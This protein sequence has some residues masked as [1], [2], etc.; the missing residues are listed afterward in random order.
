M[1]ED[2]HPPIA[3]KVACIDFDGTI[4]PWGPLMETRDPFPGAPEAIQALKANGY[5]IVIYTSRL[6]PA[7]LAARWPKQP[8]IAS[9][10]KQR[11]HIIDI[12]DRH[13]IPWDSMT[14]EK[15]PAEVYFDDKAI[16]VTER[17]PLAV[18]IAVFIGGNFR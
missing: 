5:T 15:V 2:T 16:R 3:N 7:W 8:L 12:L 6:S 4:V 10:Q 1:T 18:A 13:H 9:E 14:A 17:F 11:A